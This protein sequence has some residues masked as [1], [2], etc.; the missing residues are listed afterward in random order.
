MNTGIIIAFLLAYLV[1]AIPSSVWV[2]KL[3]FGIDVRKYGSGNAGA[4][5]S[6]RVLGTLPGL[7]V[8]FAD[9]TK[10]S[11]AV[12]FAYY[13]GGILP[14]TD[15][16]LYYKFS[17]GFTAALGH[18][19]PVYL[20]FKGGKGVATFF[21]VVL[22]IFPLAALICAIIFLTVFLLSRYVSLA[23]L[24]S[25]LA[26]PLAVLFLHRMFQ[27]PVIVFVCLI[28]VIIFYTH[29]KNIQRLMNGT[30]NKIRFKKS[31]P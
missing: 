10:G 19:F 29:R 27:I 16:F 25:S 4:T 31:K 20:G 24:V 26:F 12:S 9:I 8:L 13:I 23:S 17:L 5:N 6:F 28:P 7:V 22:A 15:T 1:G 11:I 14:F 18:I 30:E 3:F 2:G 21:G